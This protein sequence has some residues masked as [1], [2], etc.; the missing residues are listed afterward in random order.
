MEDIKSIEQFFDY[1]TGTDPDCKMELDF[2]LKKARQYLPESATEK[3]MQAYEFA[4]KAHWGV[5][6][7]SGEPYFV[8]P[9]RATVFL[10]EINPDIE[11]IQGCIL[12]DVI[13]DTEYTYDD[14][15][16]TFWEEVA[17][18]CEGVTKVSTLKYRGEER[19]LETFKKTFLAMAKDLR[20]IFIKF[21]DRI[22]NVQTLQFHPKPEK[23]E[24]IAT[25]TLKMF[26][27][28]AK[29]LWLYN[30]Q[31][32]LE[33]GA[34]KNLQPDR[35]ELIM[36]YL[37]KNFGNGEKIID[38]GIKNLTTILKK[39]GIKNFTIQGRLK[40]PFR[41]NE[42]MEKKYHTNDVSRI[43]DLLAFRVI[44]DSVSNCYMILG[45]IHKH[46]TPLIQKIKDYIAVPKFNG[47]KSVHTTILGMFRF[48]IEIQIRT[49][50]MNEIAEH[51]V[52]AHFAYAENNG[53][54]EVSSN[55]NRWINKLKEIV[56][57]Y[58]DPEKKEI[59]K[60]ELNIEVLDKSIFVYTPKG[61]IKEL[62]Q[63]SSVLDFA[64]SVHSDV[65][66]RFKNAI[67]NGQIKPLSYILKTG[68]IV[69]INTFK[70]RYS[71]VKHWIEY[72]HVPSAKSQLIKY[73]R[74]QE[75]EIRLAEAI[76]GLNEYLKSFGLPF[77]RSEKDLIQ[78]LGESADIERRI[79]GVLD[80][81]ESY[82]DIVKEAYPDFRK[83]VQEKTLQN[84]TVSETNTLKTA[85]TNPWTEGRETQVII[86]NDK[87]LHCIFCPECEAKIGDKIVAKS[88]KEGIKIHSL[89]CKALKT[90]SY[91]ALLEAHREGEPCNVYQIH[92]DL[93]FEN[94]KV[95]IL[96]ILMLF[97][98]FSIPVIK[99]ELVKED[100]KHTIAEVV[101][102][103]W[104]PAKLGFF[105]SDLQ[106]NHPL[107]TV[108]SKEIL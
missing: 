72:L 27:P 93:R 17:T 14:I 49:N 18:L 61:D 86:D 3:I 22:H 104:N 45:I 67:V 94:G 63:N 10:M 80:K 107:V 38:K 46:Y 39:E 32:Y 74:N 55:Q 56:A 15:K 97:S 24:R 103:I 95:T 101:G 21:A 37:K 4:K 31:L 102:E 69:N 75:R 13:E 48:P 100:D 54:V 44:T 64:F 98:T 42:K 41:I 8:H 66:L 28:V 58:T 62:P 52:A 12:H 36:E 79:L 99:F 40:S 77:F 47:Y 88:W 76:D 29:R 35:F 2:I 78:K 1:H 85:I 16:A 71:A 43:M 106:A 84:T 68:D 89:K 92:T 91:S 83:E 7:L 87:K 65:G 25:E 50:E 5:V 82:G 9:M 33:N 23:I 70:N 73:L 6:R 60:N 51:G 26:A 34:F 105:F 30:F 20:V 96:D 11:T 19:M 53:S 108:V 57:N 90:L 59:F 81:K